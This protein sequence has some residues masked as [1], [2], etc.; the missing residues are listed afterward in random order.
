[1]VDS[2]ENDKFDLG[3]KGLMKLFFGISLDS[4]Q[5]SKLVIVLLRN[6]TLFN[7]SLFNSRKRSTS[8]FT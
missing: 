4:H 5:Q 7:F 3:V 8:T 1:M 6:E 2:K